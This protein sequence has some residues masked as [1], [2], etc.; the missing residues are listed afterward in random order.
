MHLRSIR[1]LG[2]FHPRTTRDGQARDRAGQTFV[3]VNEL[4]NDSNGGRLLEVMFQDG[5]WMLC[6][7]SDL[8]LESP[9]I[10]GL[11]D[12]ACALA[13]AATTYGDVLDELAAAGLSP[14]MT[15]TGGMCL[16]IELREPRQMT[17]VTDVNGPLPWNRSELAGWCAC[18]YGPDAE[19]EPVVVQTTS[20]TAAGDL[21]RLLGAMNLR[22]T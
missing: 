21:L 10:P 1:P 11:S 8:N 18:T 4:D 22:R 20:T 17:L 5:Q 3:Q 19:G 12:Y 14:G 15:Q 2:T 9:A 6:S 7:T 13:R 16:A